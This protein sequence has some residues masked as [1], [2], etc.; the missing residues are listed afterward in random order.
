MPSYRL[1]FPQPEGIQIEATH[2]AHI[3]TGDKIYNVGD[4]LEHGGKR[5]VVT[6][7]PLDQPSHGESEDLM[8]WPAG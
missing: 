5:W 2:T 3:E 8:V 4:E 1:I 6:K 7:A